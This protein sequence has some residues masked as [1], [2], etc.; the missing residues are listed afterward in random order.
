MAVPK[1]KSTYSLDVE[2]VEALED[3][4]RRWKVS[5]SEA[6]R[7]VIRAASVQDAGGEP[8][9]ALDRAQE[10]MHLTKDRAREWEHAARDEREASSSRGEG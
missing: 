6:L 10:A 7:K 9:D 5:K 8:V 2:T 3:L 4:A 1:V